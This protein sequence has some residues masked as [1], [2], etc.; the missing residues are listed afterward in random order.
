[1]IVIGLDP[2]ASSRA[3]WAV[4]DPSRPVSARLIALGSVRA[5]RGD[6]DATT[7]RIA[8]AICEAVGP[9]AAV[10]VVATERP[11]DS[12][13]GDTGYGATLQSAWA[14]GWIGAGVCAELRHRYPCRIVR[15]TPP[16]PWRE[17]MF[18]EAA[19]N[20]LLLEKPTRATV[21]AAHAFHRAAMSEARQQRLVAT[22]RLRKVIRVDGGYEA[23]YRCGHRRRIEG[24]YEALAVAN[25]PPCGSCAG[26]APSNDDGLDVNAAVRA[27][28]KKVACRFVEH[29][30]PD[31]YSQLV[32]DARSRAT[33]VGKPDH[34]LA[35]VS[36]ACE[37][38]GITVWGATCAF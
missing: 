27:E 24:G 32:A 31:Q 2:S 10:D 20:G 25:V 6:Y 17:A 18:I 7:T 3:G 4:Q 21:T 19:R 28:W 33:T 1:M 26:P 23:V 34:E 13:R 16:A 12:L 9:R 8:S 14:Q 30:W 38:V 22:S 35:G 37:A 11:P 29:F 15:A 5:V 36:D